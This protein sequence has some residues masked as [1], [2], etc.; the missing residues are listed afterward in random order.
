M[1]G[2]VFLQQGTWSRLALSQVGTDQV[3]PPRIRSDLAAT[4]NRSQGIRDVCCI[5]VPATWICTMMWETQDVNGT[6]A[7]MIQRV[8]MEAMVLGSVIVTTARA[9]P[10]LRHWS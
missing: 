10:A 3:R 7:V 2:V 4:A 9:K 5:G 6:R 1:C 8:A